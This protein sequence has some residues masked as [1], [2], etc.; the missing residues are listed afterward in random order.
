MV[1]TLKV[2]VRSASVFSRRGLPRQMP[3]LFMRMV[4]GPVVVRRVVAKASMEGVE[5]M[6]QVWNVTVGA[7]GS[8]SG[9]QSAVSMGC[10]FGGT[11]ELCRSRVG[12]RPRRP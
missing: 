9:T 11:Y 8:Q 1:L 6:S 5:V 12:C 4:G 7:G 10:M 3:A 2:A